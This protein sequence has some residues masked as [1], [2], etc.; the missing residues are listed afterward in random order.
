[1]SHVR[2]NDTNIKI[3]KFGTKDSEQL[4]SD[5]RHDLK[6]LLNKMVLLEYNA[7]GNNNI[8]VEISKSINEMVCE[9]YIY[10]KLR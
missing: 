2:T 1:M 4:F 9:D 3:V 10:N 7:N 5:I 6:N 8:V